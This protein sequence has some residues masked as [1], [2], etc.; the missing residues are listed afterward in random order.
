MR[1]ALP[2]AKRVSKKVRRPRNDEPTFEARPDRLTATLAELYQTNAD[3]A[4][5]LA[6]L[7]TG[8]REA[9]ND[10]VQE[11]FVR[12]VARFGHLRHREAFQSYL[13]RAIVNLAKSEFRRKSIERRFLAS[14]RDRS[15]SIPPDV[16]SRL[17]LWRMLL[18]LPARQR[19]ALVLRY[20]ED[21]SEDETAE[22]LRTSRRAVNALVARGLDRLRQREGAEEWMS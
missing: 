4:Y 10:L 12:I 11:A 5:R 18:E 21:M 20:Y 13:R 3:G 17:A 14:H 15:V 6:Y 22:I 19:I 1:D 2:T 8:D 16:E 9:A 7:L